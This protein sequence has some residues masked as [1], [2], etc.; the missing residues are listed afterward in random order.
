MTHV[1]S[2]ALGG[3]DSPRLDLRKTPLAGVTLEDVTTSVAVQAAPG[4]LQAPF[5][6]AAL[7]SLRYATLAGFGPDQA[8]PQHA[9]LVGA[10]L[11]ALAREEHQQ[12]PFV[13]A[14][15]VALAGTEHQQAL[16][17]AALVTPVPQGYWRGWWNSGQVSSLAPD[18]VHT[19]D[20][21]ISVKEVAAF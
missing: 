18:W 20:G 9:P 3:F 5:V 19:C 21:I 10:A 7:V 14:A 2:T 16:G 8:S 6:G 13:G 12:A 17:W 4:H 11:V 1:R 15:L